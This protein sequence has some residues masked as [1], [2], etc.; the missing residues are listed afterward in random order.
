M[1]F[2]EWNSTTT[3][4]YGLLV[5]LA[6]CAGPAVYYGQ[7]LSRFNKARAGSVLP[8]RLGMMILYATPILALFVSAR[9]YVS[10]A[11]PVQWTVF[12]AVFLH[13]LKRVLE[14]LFLHKYSKPVS[15]FTT[16]LIACFYST[17][18]FVIGSLN[19]RPIP[20]PDFP[21]AF[22]VV[23]FLAG[24]AGNFYHHKL[25]AGLRKN[26][27]DYF[28]PKGGLFEFVVCPHYLFE[29]CAWLGFA[30]LSRHFAAWLILC[31]VIAYLTAQGLRTLEWYR[32][33]FADF[34]RSRKALLPFIL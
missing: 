1:I 4:L 29:I 3:A 25:L 15:L 31:F 10:A 2:P 20:A 34:P 17:A 18:A 32:A 24:V 27:L 9:G 11:S 5:F 7:S 12:G 30:L 6:L 14:S 33:E 23:F 19:Q 28:I 16:I 26:S 8:A 21:F 13:F 22:G